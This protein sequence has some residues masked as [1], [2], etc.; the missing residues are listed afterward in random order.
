MLALLYHVLGIIP[1]YKSVMSSTL[2]P[3]LK[4]LNQRPFCQFWSA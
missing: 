4:T 1:A 3:R 2:D